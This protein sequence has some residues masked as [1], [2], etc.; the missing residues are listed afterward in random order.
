MAYFVSPAARQWVAAKI[1]AEALTIGLHTAE[2]GNAGTTA[3]ANG[4][5]GSPGV[6]KIVAGNK[7][8]AA[9]GEADNDDD[10][11]I[12]TP[13]ATSAGQAISHLSY[14]IDGTYFGWVSLQAP[15]T[16]VNGVPFVIAA[17]TI[18]M[19]VEAIAQA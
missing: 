1:A 11:E 7:I 5:N 13:N 8:T 17:G 9:N 10:V 4:N 15:V 19:I 3:R 6:T 16:T 14:T 12:F 18:D 2:P